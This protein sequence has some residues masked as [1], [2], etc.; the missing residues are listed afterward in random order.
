MTTASRLRLVAPLGPAADEVTAW[1]DGV[2]YREGWT[3]DVETSG[4]QTSL[5]VRVATT[6][7][8][9]RDPLVVTHRFTLP[10]RS[11]VGDR[12]SFVG[13]L[14]HVIGKVELHERDEWLLVDQ[15]RLFDPHAIDLR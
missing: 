9:G 5:V 13:W 12:R 8:R 10:G 2:T 3:F 6:D 14:R 11:V 1:L 4:S 15:R 7:S